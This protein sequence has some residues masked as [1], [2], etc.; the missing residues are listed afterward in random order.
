VFTTDI[1]TSETVKPLASC[2]EFLEFTF[3]IGT[4]ETRKS[5]SIVQLDDMFTFD[6]GTS[7]TQ[8]FNNGEIAKI[9][10]SSFRPA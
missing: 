5:S 8:M 4:S 2:K 9:N 1:G 7:E 3:D 10:A 6:I